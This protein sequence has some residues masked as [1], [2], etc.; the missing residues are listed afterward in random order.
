MAHGVEMGNASHTQRATGTEHH[1]APRAL[2]VSCV[3]VSTAGM[4]GERYAVSVPAILGSR[5]QTP[6]TQIA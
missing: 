3:L 6:K 2:P 4:I 5:E 1:T